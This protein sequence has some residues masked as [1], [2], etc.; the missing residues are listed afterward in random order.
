[1]L[2]LFGTP[3]QR[4]FWFVWDDLAR[5]AIG[6]IILADVR[7]LQ[8]SFAA[9]DFFEARNLTGQLKSIA[10]QRNWQYTVVCPT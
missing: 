9:A 10:A 4:R 8:D 7:R 6:A 5:G 3:G 1:M 2:Y